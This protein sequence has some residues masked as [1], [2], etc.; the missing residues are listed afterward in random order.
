MTDVAVYL[1]DASHAADRGAV[2]ELLVVVDGVQVAVKP[3]DAEQVDHWIF[4]LS[5]SKCL[6]NGVLRRGVR[7][8]AP[9]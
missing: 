2:A 5:T 9:R 7:E 4:K 1:R 3:L 6:A 8:E